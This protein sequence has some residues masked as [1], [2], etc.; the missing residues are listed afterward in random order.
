MIIRNGRNEIEDHGPATH[1]SSTYE[2]IDALGVWKFSP[3]GPDSFR[4]ALRLPE[5]HWTRRTRPSRATF[6][7]GLTVCARCGIEVVLARAGQ[8]YCSP[9]HR[10]LSNQD[11]YRA[12]HPIKEGKRV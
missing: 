8:K 7:K 3:G 12:K 2:R 5:G 9:K 6:V 4:V 1:V 11:R 10:L